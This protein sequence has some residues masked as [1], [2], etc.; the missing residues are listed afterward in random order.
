MKSRTILLTLNWIFAASWMAGCREAATSTPISTVATTAATS[1]PISTVA[2]TAATTTPFARPSPQPSSTPKRTAIAT[3]R[4]ISTLAPS[5]PATPRWHTDPTPGATE[6]GPYLV[7]RKE[8][9]GYE[10]YGTADGRADVLYS[11]ETGSWNF[12]LTGIAAGTPIRF[13]IRGVLDDHYN[14]ALDS[15]SIK[16][17]V[18]DGEVFSGFPTGF[19]HGAPFGTKFAN[20]STLSIEAGGESTI[21]I[22]NTSPIG[23]AHWIALDWV[24]L[25]ISRQDLV[26]QRTD[27]T[28][29]WTRLSAGGQAKVS[30]ENVFPN[31]VRSAPSLAASRIALIYPGTVLK[32]LEGPICADGVVFWKVVSP[33]I[34]GG[35]GWTAEGD[36]ARY[37][38]VPY[39]P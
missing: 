30:E 39:E 9:Y 38:L 14:I 22:E 15:Y 36:G 1:T 33:L 16:V 26:I 2:T 24:E 6:D 29:G 19:Q 35:V 5:Q 3:D 11:G 7:L 31:R 25:Y 8:L 28:L 13:V 20:W 18:N 37:Y 27:C 17:T 4:V 21:T 32:V 34:P 12:N 10:N 23:S